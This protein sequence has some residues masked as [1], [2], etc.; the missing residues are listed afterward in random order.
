MKVDYIALSVPVFFILIGIE[1]A[2]NFYR[3][4]NYY[5]FNDSIANLSQGIG[6]QLT[7]IFM[8]TALFF[9]YK[10]IFE[11]WRLFDLPQSIWIWIIL[12]IGVD[13]FYYWFHRMSH[14]VNALWAAHIVHHQSEEY[15]LTVALRQSWFQGWFSWVFYLPLA[16]A[17]FDPIMFLTLSSF[18]TLYQFWI[19]TRAIKSMGPL[20]WILNTP[21]HHRVHHGSNPKYIDRNHAGTLII[22]DRIFGTFQ[23]EEEEVY[24]GITTPLASW[25]PIWANVHYWD[26]LLKTARQSPRWMDKINV[27]LKPPGWFPAHLGGF[28]S[29]PEIDPLIYKKYDPQY[30]QQLTGY[31]LVQFVVGLIAGS[32]IL[33][34]HSSLPSPALISGA[35]FVILTLLTCGALLEEKKWKVKFEYARLV[36]GILIVLLQDFPIGYQVIF[37][38]LNLCSAVWFYN[39]QK[40]N[41]DAEEIPEV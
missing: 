8:K 13:F 39:L 29:A 32:A 21:S 14:Q 16:F 12:F 33:F 3:K 17:G 37:C 22:W 30:H 35:T 6:Q 11:N 34:L 25:N 26:E 1:L 38:G 31:V 4:L 40:K 2:W 10:Y 23:K 41:V 20:E 28:K 27:F 7:G 24:Y 15:N 9:G 36:L 5:R 19:H 18:N